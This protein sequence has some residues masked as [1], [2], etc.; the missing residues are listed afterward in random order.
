[1]WKS[2][3]GKGYLA[4][5]RGAEIKRRVLNT[6]VSHWACSRPSPNNGNKVVES[7]IF[8][9]VS[10]G[11][12]LSLQWNV[13]VTLLIV[14]HKPL[15][16]NVTHLWVALLPKHLFTSL[17]KN[18]INNSGPSSQQA[19]PTLKMKVHCCTSKGYCDGT[20]QVW[21]CG[22]VNLVTWSKGLFPFEEKKWKIMTGWG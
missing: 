1:M 7:L 17:W 19:V 16:H 5:Q 4:V 10:S 6:Q 9:I 21:V 12:Y 11:N 2:A 13:E 14:K 3:E 20:L 18:R 15:G 22:R 8:I